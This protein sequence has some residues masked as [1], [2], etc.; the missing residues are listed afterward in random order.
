MTGASSNCS[1]FKSTWVPV[2]CPFSFGHCVVCRSLIY[3]LIT[4]L[5]SSNSSCNRIG[6][7]DCHKLPR[8]YSVCC[9][10]NQIL[11]SFKTYHWICN[12]S[13]TTGTTCGIETAHPSWVHIQFL[14]DSCDSIFNLFE[15]FFLH[16]FLPRNITEI[17]FT[18]ENVDLI[19]CLKPFSA[20]FQLEEARIPWA[21][22]W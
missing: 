1:S 10:Y 19:Y 18:L 7:Y 11:S 21:S 13:N 22:N 16:L 9:M 2:V 4:P 12:K 6:T 3:I 17:L 5:V 15:E 20:I 8:I 14:V